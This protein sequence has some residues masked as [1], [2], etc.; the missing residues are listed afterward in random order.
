MQVILEKLVEVVNYF[1]VGI[2]T[3]RY[4]QVLVYTG[5]QMPVMYPIVSIYATNSFYSLHPRLI[6]FVN[7]RI[8]VGY[9]WIQ[10]IPFALHLQEVIDGRL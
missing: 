10:D 2:E 4:R 8:T 5:F 7:R 3:L 6:V 9:R 1:E